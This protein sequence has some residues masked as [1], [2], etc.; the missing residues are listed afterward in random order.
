MSNISLLNI[1]LMV[2]AL[3]KGVWKKM[4]GLLGPHSITSSQALVYW[5]GKE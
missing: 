5:W 1:S 3:K 2:S 4:E